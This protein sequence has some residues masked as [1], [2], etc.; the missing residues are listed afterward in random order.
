[1][2]DTSENRRLIPEQR[3]EEIISAAVRL[4]CEKG[5]EGTTIRDIARAVGVTEGLLYHYFPSKAELVAECWRRRSWHSRAVAI[6]GSAGDRPVPEVLLELIRDHLASLYDNGPA[7]RMHAAE[8]L[9]DGELASMSQHYIHETH[10][11]IAEYV[12]RNQRLGRITAD[13]DPDVVAH[14]ILGTNSTFFVLHGTLPRDRW[15][16]G[17]A[18][19]AQKLTRLLIR[20][21]GVDEAGDPE[22]AHSS[23][24]PLVAQASR[25]H[26]S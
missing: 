6:V 13:A 12:R 19:L 2:A 5:Y 25:L 15:Q 9:R 1:M 3:R 22:K 18:A 17:S 14:V 20:S 10:N 7:F 23:P 11:A 24:D 4:F 26:S 16:A 8:M 21:L